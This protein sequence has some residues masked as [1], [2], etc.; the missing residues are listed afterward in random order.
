MTPSFDGFAIPLIVSPGASDLVRNTEKENARN[1][2]VVWS[3][4]LLCQV[5]DH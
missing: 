4:Q 1:I 3:A 5:N 2:V